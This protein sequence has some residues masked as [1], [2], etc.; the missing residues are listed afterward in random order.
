MTD[1][2]T[3]RQD[4]RDV[5]V[6][7]SFT[8]KR[9]EIDMLEAGQ[10]GSSRQTPRWS[11]LMDAAA[12]AMTIHADQVRK[13]S[14]VPYLGHLL[15]VASLVLEHGGDEDQA[16][17]GLLHDAIEDQG[18][19]QEPAIHGRFG[20]RVADIVRGCTDADTSPKPPWQARKE[21][22]IHHLEDASP[23][24]LLVSCAD[25]VFNARAIVTDLKTHG[26]A[27]FERFTA[28]KDGTLWYY[29]ALA[30]VFDRRMPSALAGELADQVREM[31]ELAA[32]AVPSA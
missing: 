21:A 18:A 2:D 3:Y 22:Y 9:Q 12:F 17:G 27:V 1:R 32:V 24:I 30:D 6:V 14:E 19:H 20:P 16:I 26:D 23:D 25:K 8:D 4:E 15:G 10:A 11:S 5:S 28:G 31:R 7:A 13:G 29:G